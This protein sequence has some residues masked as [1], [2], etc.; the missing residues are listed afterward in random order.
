MPEKPKGKAVKPPRGSPQR[1]AGPLLRPSMP[2]LK[3]DGSL[4]QAGLVGQG[5]MIPPSTAAARVRRRP[6]SVL[7]T[8]KG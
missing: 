8:T 3:R 6:T 4:A 7:R 2:V 5:A 1:P